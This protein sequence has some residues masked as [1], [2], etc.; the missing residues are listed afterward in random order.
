M[1]FA[2]L[3]N[4]FVFRRVFARHPAILRELLN[5]LLDLSKFEAGRMTLSR[6]PA[7]LEL[8][9]REAVN[10][11]AALFQS[12]RQTVRAAQLV[13]KYIA[14]VH[15]V[16]DFAGSSRLPLTPVAPGLSMNASTRV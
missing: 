11:F 6:A 10:E 13:S 14:G 8:L 9:V 4:D 12:R 5:D 15:Y 2:D 1:A 3:K 16:R 7:D